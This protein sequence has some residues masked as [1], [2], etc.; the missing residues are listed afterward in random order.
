MVDYGPSKGHLRDIAH[1]TEVAVAPRR[2]TFRGAINFG[3][4]GVLAF[5]IMLAH[6]PAPKTGR[7]ASNGH[8]LGLWLTS[9][10]AFKSGQ[11]DYPK[12]ILFNDTLR[13]ATPPRRPCGPF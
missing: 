11:K 5:Q 10:N 3:G 2:A 4:G 1:D 12:N 13:V 6:G 7:A 9:E 8:L